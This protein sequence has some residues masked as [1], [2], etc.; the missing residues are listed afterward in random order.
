VIG[1]APRP[2][3]CVLAL[4]YANAIARCAIH[5]AAPIGAGVA[6]VAALPV[7]IVLRWVGFEDEIDGRY[8]DGGVE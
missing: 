4:A 2:R 5:L 3:P 6:L 1:A 8:G 7:L